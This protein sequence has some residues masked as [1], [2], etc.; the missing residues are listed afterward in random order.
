MER[1]RDGERQKEGNENSRRNLPFLHAHTHAVSLPLSLPPSPCSSFR[2][3]VWW[4]SSPIVRRSVPQRHRSAVPSMHSGSR[5]GEQRRRMEEKATKGV[6]HPSIHPSIPSLSQTPNSRHQTRPHQ[7][8]PDQTKQL[9]NAAILEAES[10]SQIPQS[11]N[12]ILGTPVPPNPWKGTSAS[13]THC[14]SRAVQDDIQQDGST[15]FLLG[16]TRREMPP[17]GGHGS[18]QHRQ[19]R[20]TACLPLKRFNIHH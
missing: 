4:P 11:K 8:T 16:C 1:E 6:I 20:P 13:G 7:T 14:I 10:C 5:C 17:S 3:A 12:G 2:Q 18:I 19:T 9:H 15:I